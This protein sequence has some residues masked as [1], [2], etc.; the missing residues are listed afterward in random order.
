MSGLY[1]TLRVI[2]VISD[3]MLPLG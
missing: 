2:S 3:R 1:C